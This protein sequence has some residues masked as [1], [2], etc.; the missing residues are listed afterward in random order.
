MISLSLQRNTQ[1]KNTHAGKTWWEDLHLK[2]SIEFHSE[3]LRLET[4]NRFNEAE[5]YFGIYNAGDQSFFS[6]SEIQQV[7]LSH[8]ETTERLFRQHEVWQSWL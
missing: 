8:T 6:Y 5:T 2:Q 3:N 1:S 4:I 7:I